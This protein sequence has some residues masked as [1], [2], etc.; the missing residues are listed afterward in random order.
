M[1][2]LAFLCGAVVSPI[3]LTFWCLGRQGILRVAREVLEEVDPYTPEDRAT[4]E[5]LKQYVAKMD[6]R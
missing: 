6:S 2:I 4:V 1:A 5:R 3:V